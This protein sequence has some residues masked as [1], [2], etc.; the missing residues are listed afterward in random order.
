MQ[1]LLTSEY[2]KALLV[3]VGGSV[4]LFFVNVFLKQRIKTLEEKNREGIKTP[5][6]IFLRFFQRIAVPLAFLALL[7][8]AIK[9][10]SFNEQIQDIVRIV[11]SIIMTIIIVRS[12]NKTIEL[13]FS[14]YF[15]HDW[16]DSRRERNLKPLL[17]LVKFI[18]WTVGVI[19]LLANLG[20]DVSTALAGLGVGGI[21][22][23]IAAQGILGDLFSYLVIFFDKP[24]ELGDFIIFGDKSGVVEHIGIKSIRIRVL[25]G[26]LLI[27][28]NS[29]LNSSRVHNYKKMI[30]R[31]V[32]FN[33]RIAYETPADKV[34]KIPSIIKDVIG[35]VKT[36]EGVICDRSHLNAFGEY[37][38]N[39]ETIYYVP[40]N[41]YAIFMDTQQEIYFKLFRALKEEEIK[42]AYPTQLV[43][44]EA[45]T[46]DHASQE[47]VPTQTAK[48]VDSSWTTS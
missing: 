5:P 3:I 7:T 16:A 24:F 34:E 4:V 1:A 18:L 43:Y 25:S 28:S 48:Q 38:L 45:G 12:L 22:V 42:L 39:F 15:E 36:I 31:R 23:A 11:F 40:T 13:A 17:A 44:T 35:S 6:L 46:T 14:R 19:F 41:D 47:V 10:V 21:A 30:R 20:L 27:I 26:E 2:I 32:L 37:S 9:I 8:I 33:V 29:D